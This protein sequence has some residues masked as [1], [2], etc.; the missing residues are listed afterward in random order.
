[1]AKSFD[2]FILRFFEK[3]FKEIRSLSL[4]LNFIIYIAIFC[5]AVYVGYITGGK[6]STVFEFILAFSFI[7][8]GILAVYVFHFYNY[9]DFKLFRLIVFLGG[10]GALLGLLFAKVFQ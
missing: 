3:N 4:V 7:I 2:D 9:I 10:V 1:M 5:F 8:I 6:V